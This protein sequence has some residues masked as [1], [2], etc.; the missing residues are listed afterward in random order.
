MMRAESELPAR[1][2]L[3]LRPTSEPGQTR[4]LNNEVVST[5]G[6]R[7]LDAKKTE[8]DDMKKTYVNLKPLRKYRF[9]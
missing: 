1:P 6:G 4:Y 9:H 8:T 2:Q 7:Y 5:R 3:M